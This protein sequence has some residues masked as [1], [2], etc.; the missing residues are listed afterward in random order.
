MKKQLLLLLLTFFSISICNA[1][2][3]DDIVYKVNADEE[4]VSVT[5]YTEHWNWSS[6]NNYSASTIVV[7]PT[8]SYDN[9]EYV[10]TEIGNKAF[11][12]SHNL[13]SITLPTTITK[14][15]SYAFSC[16]EKLKDLELPESLETIEPWAF[17]NC[18]L[19]NLVIPTTLKKIGS[20]AFYSEISGGGAANVYISDLSAWLKINFGSDDANPTKANFYLN[21][22]PITDLVI[23]DDVTTLGT[24]ALR[25]VNCETLTVPDH[26][27]SIGSYAFYGCKAKNIKIGEGVHEIG[28]WALSYCSNVVSVELGLNISKI[29]TPNFNNIGNIKTITCNALTPPSISDQQAF[30]YFHGSD[31]DE[32]DYTLDDVTLNVPSG[33]QRKY[34][35]A[36]TWKRFGHIK[37]MEDDSNLLHIGDLNSD[38][39]VD[40]GDVN[41]LI[42]IILGKF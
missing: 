35:N 42:N 24:S 18:M 11:N 38:G 2:V 34:R 20:S 1:F 4:T 26:V 22:E 15:G 7:P 8:I 12:N 17:F 33:T 31:D 30:T 9:K 27:T 25:Y 41:V 19:T 16:C 37:E 28:S 3:V 21:G 39:L 32:D 40:V 10:V 5:Y 13:T 6:G 36:E 23:P 14:I 29:N